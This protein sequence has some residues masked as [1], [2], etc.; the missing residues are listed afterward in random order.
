MH[1]VRRARPRQLPLGE[2]VRAGDAAFAQRRQLAV[3]A[4][5]GQPCPASATAKAAG[6]TEILMSG[7]SLHS[8]PCYPEIKV[9][10][11][12]GPGRYDPHF[13]MA[14]KNTPLVIPPAYGLAQVNNETYTTEG[15]IS[16]WNAYVAFI[17]MGEQGNFSD[18]RLGIDINTRRTGPVPSAYR[19]SLPAPPPVAASFDASA[20]E[21]GC[22]V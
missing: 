15:P 22:A 2:L 17:Q 11:S 18:P 10:E 5:S 12:R 1:L 14:G 4:T 8:R 6:R 20:A 9:D 21:R 19:H 13:N 7:P 3:A 16:Y